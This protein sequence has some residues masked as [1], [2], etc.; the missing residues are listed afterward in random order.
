MAEVICGRCNGDPSALRL[1]AT[2]STWYLLDVTDDGIFA[3]QPEAD[4]E[5]TL[6][7]LCVECGYEEGIGPEFPVRLPSE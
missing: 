6:L 4:D 7:L 3:H 2:H 1:I 5:P